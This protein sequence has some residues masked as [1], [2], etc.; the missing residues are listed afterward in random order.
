M[1]LSVSE[2]DLRK[3]RFD[4]SLAPGRIDFTEECLQQATPLHAAGTAELL[5]HSDGEVRI[6]GR[7]K[8]EMAF[9]CDRCLADTQ[10]PVE[11]GFD[12]FYRP[13]SA[14]ARAEEVEI[15][16]GETEIGFYENGGLELDD[17]L[18]E[19]VLLALPL[20]WVCSENCKGICPVCGQNRNE[21]ACDCKAQSGAAHWHALRDIGAGPRS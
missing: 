10:I 6:L 12:L 2:M 19:Q 18:R 5:P 8:V 7:Y 17:I 4:E 3:I 13:A 21:A 14:I 11:A 9:Q 1:F 16:A 15:A 20:Q